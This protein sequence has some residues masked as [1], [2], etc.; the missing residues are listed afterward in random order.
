MGILIRKI[1][2]F[3][4]LSKC[5]RILLLL[6]IVALR[7]CLEFGSKDSLISIF[8]FYLIGF[9]MLFISSMVRVFILFQASILVLLTD[10]YSIV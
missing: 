7:I 3:M 9:Q 1:G 10:Q 6:M 2:P 4:N 8:T 5:M